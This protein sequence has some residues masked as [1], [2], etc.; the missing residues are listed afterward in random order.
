MALTGH[1]NIGV[2]RKR[3]HFGV[4]RVDTRRPDGFYDFN[5]CARFSFVSGYDFFK[6]FG[7]VT[8][9]GDGNFEGLI[10]RASAYSVSATVAASDNG[11]N[12]Y[13]CY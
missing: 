1:K 4:Y 9:F 12:R 2:A 7:P 3:F 10:A 6:P 13:D 11:K 5:F 8:E